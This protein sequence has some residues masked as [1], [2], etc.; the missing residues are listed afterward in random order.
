[1]NRRRRRSALSVLSIA[2][3]LSACHRSESAPSESLDGSRASLASAASTASAARPSGAAN[4]VDVCGAIPAAD[5]ARVSGLPIVIAE[6]S[7]NKC[8]YKAKGTLEYLVWAFLLH[9]VHVS[10]AKINAKAY[11]DMRR[12]DD[13]SRV[14]PATEIPG[15]GDEAILIRIATG[16]NK[17]VVDELEVLARK[18]DSLVSM[19]RPGGADPERV[20]DVARRAL[21]NLLAKL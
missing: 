5:M 2:L 7:S 11:L 16:K 8:V 13:E 21:P 15:L 19:Q 3:W 10:G 18:G 20:A 6:P 1:M 17:K 9:G 12:A 4:D 14:G